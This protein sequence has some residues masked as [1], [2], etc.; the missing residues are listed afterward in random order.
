M[1]RIYTFFAILGLLATSCS[2]LDITPEDTVIEEDLFSES[3]GFHNAINGLYKTMSETSLYGRELSYG[4]VEVLSQNYVNGA[5]DWF[6]DGLSNY[7]DYYPLFKYDYTSTEGVQSIIENI[8][9][10]AYFVI[11]NAN[12][13]VSKIE[14]LSLDKFKYGQEEKNLIKGEA[15]AVRAMMHFDMLRLFAPAPAVAD[16]KPY[17]PYVV[18]SPYYGGNAKETVESIMKKIEKDLL[19]AKELIMSYDTMGEDQLSRL[20]TWARFMLPTGVSNTNAFYEY[21]GYRINCLAVTGLLAR[22]YNYWG[23]HAE[24]FKQ[25]QEAADFVY[26]QEYGYKALEYSNDNQT[27]Y[28]RKFTTDLIFCLSDTRMTE[29][30]QPYSVNT[31]YDFLNINADIVKFEGVPEADAGDNR[32]RYQVERVE[33]WYGGCAYK[34]LKYIKMD[35]S[36]D[37]SARAA[38]MLPVMRLSEMHFIMAEAKA[39]EGNYSEEDGANYYLNLVREGRNCR[40]INLGIIDM[41]TFKTQLFMEVRKECFSEGQTFYY[42]KKYNEPLVSGMTPENFVVPTPQSENVN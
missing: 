36:Q 26:D 5:T 15:L 28:D 14:P 7:S 29:H 6:N 16:D 37:I 19:E 10:R 27:Q 25:A 23:K 13:I 30:Y 21:R 40:K 22:L 42:F 18:E 35:G 41:E 4:F 3:T 20:S 31:S 32:L 8:W 1:K 38:D 9:S 11:A 12:S 33:N 34:P 2:W 17:I 24:A 39:A